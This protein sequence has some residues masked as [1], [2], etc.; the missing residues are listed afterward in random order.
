[1]SN[2][3]YCRKSGLDGNQKVEI[4]FSIVKSKTLSA[5]K[6]QTTVSPT[7]Q[8]TANN[9]LS[10]SYLAHLTWE[11]KMIQRYNRYLRE[12]LGKPHHKYTF[13]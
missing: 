8:S 11:D 12:T 7:R 13:L 3:Y 5:L 10:I 1:M 9:L 6:T 4:A 2:Q